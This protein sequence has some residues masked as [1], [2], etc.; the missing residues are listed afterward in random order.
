MLLVDHEHAAEAIADDP[1][2][3]LG[4]WL[5]PQRGQEI[6]GEQA[7]ISRTP[8][9]NMHSCDR[10]GIVDHGQSHHLLSTIYLC[11]TTW[12]RPKHRVRAPSVRC[13]S[14]PGRWPRWWSSASLPAFRPL[15]S[16]FGAQRPAVAAPTTPCPATVPGRLRLPYVNA[17]W[18]LVEEGSTAAPRFWVF[19]T[20]DAA[21][22]WQRQFAGSASST[23]AGPLKIQF[24]DRNNGFIALGGTAAVFRTGDGG[25]R[26]KL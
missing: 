16:A 26:W 24:F 20:S 10:L 3:P 14:S 12:T 7:A 15:R 22:H 2:P 19:N 18:A 13:P 17:G 6:I 23:N 8:A 5:L 11:P 25:V 1:S 4:V 21:R 9:R